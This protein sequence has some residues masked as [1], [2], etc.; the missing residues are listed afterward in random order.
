MVSATIFGGRFLPAADLND[1]VSFN[2]T[3]T[4][5]GALTV[6]PTQHLGFRGSLLRTRTDAR[7]PA[8][9][10]SPLKEQSP[11]IWYYGADVVVQPTLTSLGRWGWAPFLFAGIGAKHYALKEA[12]QERGYTSLAGDFGAGFEYRFNGH[13]GVQAEAR[14]LFSHFNHFDYRD[15][16]WDWILTGGITVRI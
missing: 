3:G 1:G 12:D 4:I 6:W 13:W 9:S 14:H 2:D 15:M 11:S 8:S 10:S 5:G 7:V 16:Q